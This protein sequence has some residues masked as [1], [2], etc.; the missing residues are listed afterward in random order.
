MCMLLHVAWRNV[1]C[2]VR[3]EG[4]EQEHCDYTSCIWLAG[5]MR[6]RPDWEAKVK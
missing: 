5:A 4:V 2:Q 3:M 6:I 1:C